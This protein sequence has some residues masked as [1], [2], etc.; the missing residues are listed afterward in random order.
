L[1]HAM[2]TFKDWSGSAFP[3]ITFSATDHAGVESVVL[4]QVKNGKQTVISDWME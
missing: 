2:E 4:V 3:P 1:I